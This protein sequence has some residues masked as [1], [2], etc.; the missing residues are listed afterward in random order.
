MKALFEKNETGVTIGLIVLYVV[1]N[2]YC[3][4]NFGTA[5]YR[6]AIINT[7]FSLVLLTLIICLK[8]TS[9][10]G[11]T[12]VKNAKGYLYF[13]PLVLIASVNLWNGLNIDNTQ[14]EIVFHVIMM[15]NAGFIEEIIFRGFLFRMMEKDNVKRAMVVSALTFGIGHIAN[16]LSGADVVQTLI[17]ICYAITIGFLFVTI[18]Y[19]SKSLIPCIITHAVINALSIFN[20]ENE[21]VFYLASA[22]LV[23]VPLAYVFYINKTVKE[24]E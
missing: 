13:I 18:F 22:F 15:L 16:L 11:L 3:K 8:R 9:Y 12:K 4:S 10:Y 17:Q 5:D 1:I 20:G 2:S 23:V 6:S 19:K 14:A 21:V 24:K 7:V